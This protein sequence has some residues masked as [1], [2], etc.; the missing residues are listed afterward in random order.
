MY[1]KLQRAQTF[2]RQIEKTIKDGCT[3]VLYSSLTHPSIH[4][5]M[6]YEWKVLGFGTEACRFRCGRMCCILLLTLIHRHPH[7]QVTNITRLDWLGFRLYLFE[8]LLAGS[9]LRKWAEMVAY[10]S[11][12]LAG[13]NYWKLNRKSC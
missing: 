3:W 7:H 9:E 1:F 11:Y 2:F 10:D 4:T 6:Q 8:M 5:F 12:P 13:I